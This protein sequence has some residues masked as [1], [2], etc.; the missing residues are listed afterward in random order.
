MASILII[1]DEKSV[2]TLMSQVINSMGHEVA[3]ALTLENGLRLA[4]NNYVDVVFLDVNL[5][6]GNGLD[7]LSTFQSLPSTPEV[8]VITGY[9]NPDS[10]ELA[11]K[12]NAWDYIEKPASTDA[13][14]LILNRAL[15]YRQERQASQPKLSFKRDSIIG[16]GFKIRACLDLAVRGANND[17]NI[18]IG[19]ETGTGKELFARAIHTNSPR[20]H[21]NFAVVDCGSLPESIVESLLFG[22]VKGAFTGAYRSKEGFIKHAD[23]GTLFLDEVGELSLAVQKTFLRVLQE[24]RFNPIGQTQEIESDFRLIAASNRNLDK[25]TKAG[26]FREDLLFRLRSIVIELPPLRERIEDIKELTLHYI[27]TLCESHRIGIKGFSP[28]FFDV[29]ESYG[30]PGNVRELFSA[31]ESTF[32]QAFYE[33]TLF[34][35]HLPTHVRIQVARS[36]FDAPDS[37]EKIPQSCAM[38]ATA[39][40][41]WQDF[42]KAYIAAG[43]IQYLRDLIS[44][45]NGNVMEAAQIAGLSRPH[46][47]GLLRKYNLS[48]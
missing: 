47:Y 45:S 4:E 14:R 17:A 8:I 1:D 40:S 31:L 19:G 24:H 37:G 34:P 6:D 48:N 46:L 12:C 26:N 25:M 44:Q 5:P 32:A 21:K 2:C 35:K 11:V 18:L 41:K 7:Q 27:R 3:H 10:A 16:N 28:D 22:H 15:S 9:A 39:L 30:W 23:E 42:R 29:L 36:T 13:I 43:E 38:T 33:N 20:A